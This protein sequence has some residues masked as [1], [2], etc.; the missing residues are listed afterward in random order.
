MEKRQRIILLGFLFLLAA[1]TLLCFRVLP[2]SEEKKSG[3]EEERIDLCLWYPWENEGEAYKKSFLEAVEEF[4]KAHDT[5]Q[6]LAEGTEM[7]LYREKL[8]SAI[9]S[10]DTP[11]IYFCFGDSYLKGAVS[12]RKLLKMNEYLSEDINSRIDEEAMEGMNYEGGI[13]GLGFSESVAVLFVN[14]E[15]FDACGLQIPSDWGELEEVCREFIARDITPFACSGDTD[16]GFRLYLESICVSEAGSDVC[17]R[18]L[19]QEGTKEDISAFLNG[20]DKFCLLRDMGAFG[21]PLFTR[22]TQDVENDFYLSR[23]P[24]YLAKSDFAGNVMQEDS[25]L[26]GKLSAVPFP[27]VYTGRESLGGVSDAFVVNKAAEHP[28]VT[29]WALEEI[30]ENFAVK[31][32]ERGAGIPVWDTGNA[33]KPEDDVCRQI[34]NMAG[35]A[36]K[37]MQY[38]E[39]YLDRRRAEV[40]MRGSEE[41]GSGNISPEQFVRELCEKE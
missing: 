29:V 5:V 41:L 19:R 26:H 9:A 25:P 7:E 12:S 6:V 17:K 8:P 15:M 23:I 33:C 10:N 2:K 35:S 21:S 32:Y 14:R 13:Y 40:F 37:R 16:T 22:S 31:L 38:W 30:L 24:M 27:G 39:F 1:I 3:E 20:V 36:D 11:D 28:E 34:E 4:N 18:V